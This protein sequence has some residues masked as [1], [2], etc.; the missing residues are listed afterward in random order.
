M[1]LA[2]ISDIHG[3]LVYFNA[4]LKEIA[5][6]ECD[7]LV[8]LGDSVGYFPD[9]LPCLEKL[10]VLGSHHLMG[11]HEAMMLGLA[12]LSPE[13]ERVYSL[14]A[15]RQCLPE[16]ELHKLGQLLP[17]WETTLDVRKLLF[18]H[19][20]PWDPLRGYVY[21]D[22]VKESF[23][24]LP[25]DAV[26]MGH[27]HRP[28]TVTINSVRVVN[29]GSCGLPRDIGNSP[30]FAVYNTQTNKVKIHRVLGDLQDTLSKYDDVHPA[31]RACLL[32]NSSDKHRA[33]CSPKERER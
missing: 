24:M 22:T 6:L 4:C 21:P 31:V 30:S 33:S 13:R 15:T 26:F 32:R 5:S 3:N 29:T 1:K 18:V 11:N 17:F 16:S 28:F 23:G 7:M 2:V 12:P 27:T 9:A 14:E 10:H 25:Y 20:S 19:G 8:C